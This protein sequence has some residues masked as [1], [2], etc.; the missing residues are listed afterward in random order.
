MD[1]VVYWI[2][3]RIDRV[4]T[5][6]LAGFL[7]AVKEDPSGEL[8]KDLAEALTILELELHPDVRTL[9]AEVTDLDLPNE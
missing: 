2:Q 8:M 5:D 1:R 7:E 3:S 6:E 4:Q 9:L